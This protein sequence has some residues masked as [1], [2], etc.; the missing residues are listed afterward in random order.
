MTEW[1]D[2]EKSGTAYKSV[3]YLKGLGSLSIEDWEMVM[4]ERKM[5]KVRIDRSANKYIDIAFGNSADKRKKWL[6]GHI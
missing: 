6:S 1:T 3:R 2:F 5:F 4:K